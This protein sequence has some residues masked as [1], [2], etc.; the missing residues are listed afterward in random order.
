MW[1]EII[2]HSSGTPKRH[3]DVVKSYVKGGCL[4]LELEEHDADENP[5]IIAY[6]LVNV[7]SYAKPHLR[8]VGTTQKG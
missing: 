4:L 1:V 3:E 2:F 5:V 7:F 8:H 6:P